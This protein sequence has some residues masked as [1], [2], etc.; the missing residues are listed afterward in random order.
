[1]VKRLCCLGGSVLFP[2]ALLMIWGQ[3]VLAGW[4]IP[5]NKQIAN[6]LSSTI[7]IDAVLYDGY[8]FNDADEAVALR[9]IA[10]MPIQLAGWQLGDRFGNFSELPPSLSIEP[11]D[12]LWIARD[13]EAFKRQFGFPAD[14]LLNP[15]PGFANSG[16]KVVLIDPDDGLVDVLVYGDEDANG[17]GWLGPA[18]QPYIVRGLFGAEG[19][20]LYR[21]REQIS[22]MPVVDSN[23]AGDWAQDRND[24][25]NGRK[26]NYPGWSLGD[27]FLTS[28]VTE[29]AVFTVSIAPD[30]ALETVVGAIAGAR[31]SIYIESF[32]FENLIISEALI[33]AAERGVE[34]KVLLEGSPP[35][36]LAAQE[37][38]I[39]RQLELAGG[40][41]WFMI[42]NID[43]RIHDR[44]RYLHGKFILIDN[45]LA[46]V[47]TE[48]LSPNSMPFD[49]K[50]DGTWGR[51][52]VVLFTDAS[53]V[54][55]R[56]GKIFDDDLDPL[57][58]ADLFRW[59]AE[60]PYYGAPPAGFTPVTESGGITYSVYYPLPAV[61]QGDF[62]FEIQQ[63]PENSLRDEDGLL[64]LVSRAGFG[65]T[66][67]VQQL[68]EKPFWGA[69]D[70][71][72]VDDPNPR[73]ESYIAAARRGADVR[74]LLDN[75]FDD[76]NNP[77][78]NHA[79]CLLLNTI[80]G[81]E[82]LR[83][84]CHLANPTGL[85]IHNK[86]ILAHVAGQK[87]VHVGSI[88][89]SELSN[90]GNRE[91]ALIVQSGEAYDLLSGMFV[92]DTPHAITLP[93]IMGDYRGP[94][95]YMLISEVLY[96]SYGQDEGEFIE[97][98]NPT[99][100]GIDISGFSLSD[101]VAREDFEDLRRFPP[102]TVVAAGDVLVVATSAAFFW[103]EYGFW[104]NFEI[105]ETVPAVANL[106]DDSSWGD[107]ETFLRLGNSGD[108][109]ILR[110]REDG[111]VDVVV[112][113]DG[114]FPGL[115][116]CPLLEGTNHSLERFPYWRD[117]DNCPI[118]FRDWPFPSPGKRP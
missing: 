44:Y 76:R 79:T 88:N 36:G 25:I 18:L 34:V 101:A 111:L 28:Q 108:E 66:V 69:S 2:F 106:I 118:D 82:K 96:D 57:N 98:V 29:T 84:S 70:S 39:C 52:G 11:D 54:V 80:A 30:N 33:A 38:Y 113:G 58:H 94:A 59:Q 102:G 104:P 35:G 73:L 63:A 78:S 32:T 50:V 114:I 26:V 41:C 117:S 100:A 91:V 10:S 23:R 83:L 15:W 20:V 75:F 43:E 95:N 49:D 110:D 92:R 90:K 12:L 109:V 24:P 27:F 81:E 89:G 64:G 67:L 107:R 105:L 62:L 19:Q 37:K 116:G 16:D 42:S 47:S 86:M 9:N 4:A 56:L 46:G 55:S 103:Q 7:L 53:S 85:G 72:R 1:M 3:G 61:F 17:A 6:P 74:L 99:A 22:G 40:E 115:V 51:R 8:E 93:L 77:T 5:A 68:V 21:K 31:E 87:Y 13:G 48:N 60:H 14:V 71:N 45:R 97:L 65:D 112:Y